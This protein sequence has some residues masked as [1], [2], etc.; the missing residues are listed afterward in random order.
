VRCVSEFIRRALGLRA[1]FGL[2]VLI[3]PNAFHA[4][5]FERALTMPRSTYGLPEVS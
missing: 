5:V 2:P 4:I 3:F 1:W